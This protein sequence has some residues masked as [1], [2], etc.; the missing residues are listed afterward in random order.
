[1]PLPTQ[2]LSAIIRRVI[3]P[4][5]TSFPG[6]PL[7]PTKFLGR[8]ARS[9]GLNIWGF[10]KAVEALDLDIVPSPQSSTDALSA[11][12]SLLG[13]P[14]G[15]GGYGRGVATTASGG[16][17]TLTG[18]KGTTYG[19]GLVATAEDGTTQI[20]LTSTVTIPGVGTGF[21][22]VQASFASL[23]A[24]SVANL[25][26]T[27]VC[28]WQN[29]PIGA[30]PTFTLSTGL[31]GAN[32]TETN[33][34]CY[35][36]IVSRLQTP[37]HGGNA[38]DLREWAQTIAGISYAYIY[39]R[40]SGTGTID[41]V[42]VLAASGQARIPSVTQQNAVI[43]YY[44]TQRPAG[45]EAI[46]V[47]L[48]YMPTANG[49]TLRVRVIPTGTTAG[50]T[51]N[52]STYAFDWDDTGGPYTV[53]TGGYSAGP[54]ATLRLNTIAP[55]SLKNAINAYLA[56][57]GT[58]PR[59]Q[60]LSTGGPAIN[61]PIGV[62]AFADGGGK[63]T[64]TLDTVPSGWQSPSNGDTVYAYGP[65]VATIAAG[66]LALCDALGSS[67]ASNYGDP[68]TVWN[69][70]LAVNQIARVAE[71]AID[72]NGTP[73][74]A[75]VPVGGATIDG[76]AVDVEAQDNTPNAPEVLFLAHVAVTQ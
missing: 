41:A 63:T 49:H 52:G 27:T 70:T 23:T 42:I 4:W 45:G 12:A 2:T 74:V 14:N 22:S 1:M 58:K 48:P 8:A 50:N 64:L 39:P 29:P 26:A 67:R 40:R 65:V 10:Q 61:L 7:G 55:Q 25:A 11:W 73:L 47:L 46:N 69:D 13:L 33:A 21:G 19:A 43:A 28:S 35:G 5:R 20:Q 32:D 34:A 51:A 18:V 30:D 36:R 72:T 75:E 68:L 3:A 15:A 17:A 9:V 59:L 44:E 56:G 57:T 53:D 16:V 62:V 71:D 31:S 76:A 24:G 6:Y 66:E 38:Q 37:P 54:P 60:V